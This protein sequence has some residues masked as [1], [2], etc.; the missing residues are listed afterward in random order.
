[1][2]PDCMSY[3]DNYLSGKQD[4]LTPCL[5]KS[6]LSSSDQ[7]CYSFFCLTRGP[8]SRSTLE[9]WCSCVD[10]QSLRDCIVLCEAF[11]LLVS[12]EENIALVMF[13]VFSFLFK[14]GIFV[15]VCA[16][17]S[18]CLFLAIFCHV[19]VFLWWEVAFSACF[20]SLVFLVPYV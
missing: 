15:S 1:M 16:V 11:F 20:W 8:F 3:L 19:C 4:N 7:R 18:F 13:I 6:K 10:H 17:Y 5:V 2:H 14:L 9:R 12:D